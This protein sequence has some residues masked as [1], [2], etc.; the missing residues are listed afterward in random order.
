MNTT[1]PKR[2]ATLADAVAAREARMGT[3]ITDA[4]DAGHTL[5]AQGNGITCTCGYTATCTPRA[6]KVMMGVHAREALGQL[7]VR[8]VA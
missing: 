5:T 6:A 7:Q 1:P 8:T 2:T 4:A 3:E